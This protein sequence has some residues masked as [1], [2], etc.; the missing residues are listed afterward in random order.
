MTDTELLHNFPLPT[1]S[2]EHP[3]GHCD[4]DTVV[5]CSAAEFNTWLGATACG[6]DLSEGS[7][8]EYVS[9]LTP[10]EPHSICQYGTRTR[11]TGM[12][13]S[14]WICTLLENAK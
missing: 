3:H 13:T 14:Q 7:P 5:C 12:I 4:K 1:I 6:V 2:G 9:T 11:W 10:P 8:G